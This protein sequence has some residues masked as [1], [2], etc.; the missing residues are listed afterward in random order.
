MTVQPSSTAAAETSVLP[1]SLRAHAKYLLN[2]YARPPLMFTHGEGC[3][4][5]EESGRRY[6]DF[7]AGIAVN[8]LGHADPG[9]AEVVAQQARELVHTSNLYHHPHSGHLAE[10]LVEGSNAVRPGTFGKVF[11][12]NSGTEANEAALKL[13]RKW[14]KTQSAGKKTSTKTGVVAFSGAFHGRSMGALSA[15]ATEKY[16]LPFEPLVP[17]FRHETFDDI[18]AVNKAITEDTCAVLVEP[19]QGEGGINIASE[20]FLRALRKRCDEVNAL[21]IYDEIQ[22]GLGR[23]GKLWAHH[24]YADDCVPDVLT[25]AKPLANGI[26]IGAMLTSDRAAS[27]LGLGEHGTT[28]GGAPLPTRVGVHVV[29]RI[30]TPEFLDN[31]TRVGNQLR[32]GLEDVCVA[33]PELVAEVRGVGLLI[34]VEFRQDPSRFVKL[35]MERG[36]L[37]V[38]AGRQTVRV[39]PPL[40][41]GETEIAEGTRI[42][43]EALEALDKERVASA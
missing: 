25:S 8:A 17:G 14:G 7:T 32:K 40:T 34:G 5:Y 12:S 26:P 29:G 15:T 9:V 2:V 16:R 19:M 35:C 1:A 43:R 13:A 11:F 33:F 28:F 30:N 37:L 23:T 20:P 10:M 18:K 21:L 4:L 6:L 22:C 27:C 38:A 36:L 24:H 3:Y 31:V 41:V 39:V 42:W